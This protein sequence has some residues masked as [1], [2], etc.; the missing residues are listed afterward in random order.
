MKKSF[1]T[2]A[3]AA[4]AATNLLFGATLA[5]AATTYTV[6]HAAEGNGDRWVSGVRVSDFD[7]KAIV[8]RWDPSTSLYKVAA[9]DRTSNT[10]VIL[11]SGLLT[12]GRYD[13]VYQFQP[14]GVQFDGKFWMW[15]ED[16]TESNYDLLYS[17]GTLAGTGVI[18]VDQEDAWSNYTVAAP[19]G[20]YFVAATPSSLNHDLYFYNGSGVTDLDVTDGNGDSFPFMLRNFQGEFSF[21][22]YN[23]NDELVE[24]YTA[25][26]GVKTH[27]GTV[28]Y[29]WTDYNNF[30]DYIPAASDSDANNAYAITWDYSQE[31]SYLW[32]T[33]DVDT[34]Y[35]RQSE[36]IYNGGAMFNGAYYFA[37]DRDLNGYFGLAKA[38]GDTITSDHT[39]IE[40]SEF[41]VFGDHL[42]FGA[43]TDSSYA[44]WNLYKMGTD[45]VIHLVIQDWGGISEGGT[46]GRGTGSSF[47]FQQ[48]DGNGDRELWVDD[49]DGAHFV[50][51]I[52]ADG[53]S[54]PDY[55]GVVGNEV[56]F[57][58]YANSANEYYDLYCVSGK[59]GLAATGVDVAPIGTAGIL[60]L[61]L[62]GGLA[63]IGRR[64]AIAKR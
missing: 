11:N 9:T 3:I 53:S 2:G 42:Y 35:T 56:C 24:Q 64:F 16:T 10:T 50:S 36:E 49:A 61:I 19:D 39:Y 41:S 15:V 34:V 43:Y 14:T 29:M 55:M 8:L 7:G 45:G 27:V 32:W 28:S 38:V 46:A 26:N 17:D 47:F 23:Y 22:V 4:V 33:N 44:H 6:D 40:P 54:N 1:I 31:R 62:G 20:I 12:D 5:N 21:L 52:L 30:E 63:I 25:I 60:T 58:A 59:D 51:N 48:A 37:G 18:E 57:G 13:V